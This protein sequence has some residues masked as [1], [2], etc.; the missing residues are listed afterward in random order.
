MLGRTYL[1]NG[2]GTY[3]TPAGECLS[4]LTCRFPPQSDSKPSP[5]L[6]AI[7]GEREPTEDEVQGL[8]RVL[9]DIGGLYN[10]YDLTAEQVTCLKRKGLIR[11]DAALTQI[12]LL[13]EEEEGADADTP[14]PIAAIYTAKNGAYS[15]NEDDPETSL[16]TLLKES[17]AD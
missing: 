2:D 4:C 14:L 5:E 9:I 8:R 17:L 16:T 10:D 6:L 1:P 7:V 12:A 13:P 11:F 3:R 15:D